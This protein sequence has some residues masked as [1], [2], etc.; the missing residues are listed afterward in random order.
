MCTL[1]EALGR[2]PELLREHLAAHASFSKDPFAALNTAFM[3]DGA[4]ILVPSAVTEAGFI[5]LVFATTAGASMR[6]LCPRTLVIAGEASSVRIVESYVG[7][8]PEPYLCAPVTEIVV[9]ARARVEHYKFTGEGAAGFHIAKVRV[10]QREDSFLLSNVLSFGGR[11]TRTQVATSLAGRGAECRLY[12]LYSALSGEHVDSQTSI[13]HAEPNCSSFELYHGILAGASSGVFNGR[14]IVRPQASGTNAKQANK[15]LLLSAKAVINT[16]PELQIF[17]DDVKCTH[18]ATIG[19]LSEEALFY[20][21]SRGLPPEE[22]RGMLIGAFASEVAD[23]ISVA[24][25]RRQVEERLTER[26]ASGSQAVG[27][28]NA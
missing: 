22:A 26:I 27:R 3:G 2:E 23:A 9:G 8:S 6:A 20:L 17:A 15:N 4:F 18:A 11:L 14:I 16:K 12:G 10:D 5:H 19:R 21:R 24:T 7:L 13:E 1:G 28:T 25:L